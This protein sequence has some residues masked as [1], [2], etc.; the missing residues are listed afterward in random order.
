MNVLPITI[1]TIG[2][3]VG[4]GLRI[5]DLE[6]SKI[7]DN[8]DERR[9][10]LPV[11]AV[12]SRFKPADDPRTKSQFAKDNFEFCT[13]KLAQ[14]VMEVALAPVSAIMNQQ[15]EVAGGLSYSLTR[16]RTAIATLYESFMTYIAGFFKR[17]E[18]VVR[19]IGRVIQHLRLAFGRV[20]AIAMSM[21]FTGLTMIRG[22]MNTIDFAIR[23]VVILL[24][25]IV[26]LLIILFFI[27]FPFIPF[28][29]TLIVGLMAVVGGTTAASLEAYRESFCFAGDTGCLMAD[30]NVVPIRSIR[31]GDVLAGA[32]GR[33]EAVMRLDGRRTPLYSLDGCRVS[34]SHLVLGLTG[35]HP[36]SQDARASGPFAPVEAEL[37]CLNTVGRIIPVVGVGRTLLFRDWEE[38]ASKDISGQCGWTELVLSM[39]NSGMAKANANPQPE[40][41]IPL[42]PRDTLLPTRTGIAQAGDINIGDLVGDVSTDGEIHYTEVT[43]VVDGAAA[44]TQQIVNKDGTWVRVEGPACANG[45]A[46]FTESGTHIVFGADGRTYHIRDFSEVGSENIHLTYPYVASRLLVTE[47]SSSSG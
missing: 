4:L 25:I 1:L 26:A 23:V 40:A 46:F 22:M 14:Q 21:I 15:A 5:A 43:G 33:V 6:M 30:G 11:M 34:G 27:L 2:L 17:Y 18:N 28:F 29:L 42:M 39:L 19:E 8:W 31:V 12:A 16:V 35:W 47:S 45:R 13:E 37:Y 10:D 20:S 36:V 3:I 24:G 41:E 32:A 44:A 38:I 7:R 9:C